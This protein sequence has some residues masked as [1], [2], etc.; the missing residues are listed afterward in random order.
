MALSSYIRYVNFKPAPIMCWAVGP[1]FVLAHPQKFSVA[2]RQGFE[3]GERFPHFG[4]GPDL[5]Q[6]EA[7]K[8]LETCD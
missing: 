3:A 4:P 6:L 2:P 7:A 1:S 8:L 5:S